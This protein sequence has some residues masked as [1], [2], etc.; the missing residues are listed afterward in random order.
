MMMVDWKFWRRGQIDHKA[1]ARKAYNKKLYGEAEPHLRSLLKEG[2]D[3]AWALDVL[4]R[5]LMNTGRHDE[6]VDNHLRLEACTE[7]KNAHWNRLLRSSSN[8][9]RWDVFLDCLGRTT[10]VDDTTHELIDRAFRNHHDYSWQLQVIEKLRPMDLSWAS[11][12]GLDILISSGDIEGAR[13]EIAV[14]QKAGTPSEVTSLKMVMVLIESNEFNEATQLALT[15]LDDDILEETELAVVD[16]IVRLERKR[17]DFGYTKRALEGV[18]SALLLWPSHPGLHELASRIHWGLAD[19][20]K[21]IKHAAKALDNQPDNFRAQSF[22][23]RGLVK[24]GDMDRL[25]TAVDAA[26]VSH[27]RRYDPHRIGIDIAFY[28]SIDFPEVL[29]RCDVGLEFRPDAIRFS[30]QKSLAL[31]AMGEFEYAQEIAE[32]MVNEFPE[33]TDANLC[34][35]QIMRVRGDGEGQIA[36]INNFLQLK[37][38]T[39]FLSTDS[40]NHSITIGN[41]SC[42][43]ENAYVNG[44]LVSVIMTTWGRDELLDV[45]INSILDQTHRN[46]ELIIVDDKS[47]DDCFDHLLSLANRDSRIRVFQVEEN[48]GTYLAKNFGLT[49]AYG[50]LIT[51]MDSDDWC[52]P[53]R[54]QKQVKTLQTQP[55]VVAT[56]HDYFRIESNSSIP[57]RNGIAVRMA[58]ISLMIR[59]EARER[60]GFFDC[61][62]VG[63]DSEYIERIQAVFGVDSFVRENIPSMFMT[64]HAASLTGGG[65][66]HISW[67]SIT[68]D[69]FFN[70]GSWM[71]W[72]RRVKNGESAGYVAHPQR[73]REFEAPDAML[74]SRLHWTPNVTLFSERMLERTKRWWNPK[75]VLPVKHLSRKIAGRDWAESHGVKSPELYWQSE[76]IGDLPELA[77]LP[78]E[79]TIKPDIGWSAKNIFCLRDGQNLLDHR[80]WTRQEIIDSIT[81][82]DYLQTRTVIFFAEELLKPES[83]TEGDFLP[84][85]YKFYCF[86][87]KIAMVHCVLRISNVD[88]HLN[89]HHY[90]DESLYPVIQRVMDVREVPDEPFP[91]PECWEEML[92]D[93]RSLGSKLGCFMRIDMYATGDGP[94]FGEFTPTP[95]GGKGFTE[96]A[97]KYLATFWK[98]LEGDDEGSITEPPEWVVEG[99]LM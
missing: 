47:D 70:R 59:K 63:A 44:P 12:K 13:R 91:F 48:G 97:D 60:I 80:R 86:G 96:W 83:S 36:T 99:G 38:L 81:E 67:R 26:I 92:D 4:S 40:V 61:L 11:L 46:I 72:H 58:C 66:F 53:Q 64:Q 42:E 28:E 84:R 95:E 20:V 82:D 94:V 88:K 32:N 14:L 79:V 31:A 49:L 30:I 54:I 89:V 23:L 65:R 71:A 73:V 69:R 10:V 98:G 27:P 52:H 51:F 8:A 50:E 22:F 78:N 25:R 19:E 93:V 2:G 45:A 17:F 57:F 87:G 37:G 3:D 77:E 9:R 29:R 33:D 24:L 6:A 15:I 75:T 1:K 74:A 85:D 39:P 55:E 34:L 7:V 41:L 35:S 43:P 62:R 76:N 16:I 18:Y 56:I 5:L 90:L 21:V 68:G